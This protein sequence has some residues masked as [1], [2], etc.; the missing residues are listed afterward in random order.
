[1]WR[2][3]LPPDDLVSTASL[4]GSQQ[5]M[6]SQPLDYYFAALEAL[7]AEMGRLLDS[8]P[9]SVLANTIVFFIG[10]NG[11]P[12]R[13]IQAPFQRRRAKASLYEGGIHVPMIVAGRDVTRRGQ[14]EE[15][16]VNSTDLFATIANLAGIEGGSVPWPQDSISFAPLLTS[17]G[18]SP[19]T[20]AYSE[21]FGSPGGQTGN[22]MKQSE[23]VAIRDGRWKYMDTAGNGEQLFDLSADPYEQN[24]LL[25]GGG[26]SADADAALERLRDE[27]EK[28]HASR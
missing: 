8:I 13:T 28:L 4:D 5:E 12:N 6:R 2:R 19:R 14:R 10:N 23:G 20:F 3:T 18:D 22:R 24:D 11:T 16:L 15:A 27:V 9:A 17:G 25:A 7:D 1:M 21:L 26:L